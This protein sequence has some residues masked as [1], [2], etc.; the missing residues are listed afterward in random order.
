M[1]VCSDATF[2]DLPTSMETELSNGKEGAVMSTYFIEIV[3]FWWHIPICQLTCC[4]LF[5]SHYVWFLTGNRSWRSRGC[6]CSD[7]I[8]W[9]GEWEAAGRGGAAVCP[10]HEVV[11]CGH[12]FHRYCVCTEHSLSSLPVQCAWWAWA[13]VSLLQQDMSSLHDELC[14]SLQ[15]VP[16]QRQHI[17]SQKTSKYVFHVSEARFS[18]KQVV[19]RYCCIFTRLKA[20]SVFSFPRSQRDVSHCLG[21]PDMAF[22]NAGGAPKD[23]VLQRQGEHKLTHPIHY[24]KI[25]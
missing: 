16:S 19:H 5:L 23:H 15:R 14:V 4:I 8:R 13:S 9:W 24:N 3:I 18:E 22:S 2:R 11:H 25:R 7:W 1:L 17:L 12:I 6:R 20:T 10:V 21:Q